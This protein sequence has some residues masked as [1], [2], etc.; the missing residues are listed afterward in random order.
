LYRK[1]L[2]YEADNIACARLVINDPRY[3]GALREWAELVLAKAEGAN[4]RKRPA[5][6]SPG[7]R[8]ASAG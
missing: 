4:P 6:S 3:Q 2:Q 5:S 8:A 1:V 7:K